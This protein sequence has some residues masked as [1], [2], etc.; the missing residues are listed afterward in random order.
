[1]G[2]KLKVKKKIRNKKKKWKLKEAGESGRG[3]AHL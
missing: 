2:S 1:M 3:G